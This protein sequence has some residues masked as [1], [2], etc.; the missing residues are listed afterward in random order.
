MSVQPALLNELNSAF[1]YR[2]YTSERLM[3]LESIRPEGTAALHLNIMTAPS[4]PVIYK[5]LMSVSEMPDIS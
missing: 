4:A 2:Q 1:H 5:M 3:N